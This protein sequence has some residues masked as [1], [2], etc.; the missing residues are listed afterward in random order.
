MTAKKLDL[1]TLLDQLEKLGFY[2]YATP[3][4]VSELK[5]EAAKTGYLFG[6]EGARRDYMADSEDLAEGGVKRFVDEILPLLEELGVRG[7]TLEEDFGEEGYLVFVNGIRLV[8]YTEDEMRN[9]DIWELTTK[10]AFALVNDLLE[11][12]GSPERVYQLYGGNDLRAIFL[13]PEMFEAIRASGALDAK[14]MPVP[15]RT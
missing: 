10:R 8:M 15:I 14:E 6:G 5:A 2:R 7:V 1:G 11:K 3:G 4:Q 12:A 9:G 13:T